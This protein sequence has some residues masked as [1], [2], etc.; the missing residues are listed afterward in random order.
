VI[1]EM[2]A[3]LAIQNMERDAPRTAWSKMLQLREDVGR[4][5]TAP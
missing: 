3:S 4:M 2:A 1:E 5:P